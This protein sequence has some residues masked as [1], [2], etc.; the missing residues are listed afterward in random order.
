MVSTRDYWRRR[1]GLGTARRRPS[2]PGTTF[3]GRRGSRPLVAGAGRHPVRQHLPGM[4]AAVLRWR[5]SAP[6]AE[7]K[8]WTNLTTLNTR[9]I[10]HLGILGVLG[11]RDPPAHQADMRSLS[12]LPF[13][14]RAVAFLPSEVLGCLVALRTTHGAIR[15]LLKRIGELSGVEI[16]PDTQTALIE[17]TLAMPGVLI[18]GVPGAGGY[19]AVF[20][21]L[22]HPE[23][24]AAVER[25]WLGHRPGTDNL[26]GI[27]PLAL[28]LDPC[29]L[30]LH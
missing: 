29:G 30:L 28:D 26:P 7:R 6:E 4:A 10:E 27:L 16:E 9:L 1:W 3:S 11:D 8:L 25:L 15:R 13:E 5:A 21:V 19:D 18:A 14:R 23:A 2:R 17:A 22:L 12:Q 24:R 20:A